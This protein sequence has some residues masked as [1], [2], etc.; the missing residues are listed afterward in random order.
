MSAAVSASTIK[1]S[2][3]SSTWQSQ[4]CEIILCL[5]AIIA[6]IALLYGCFYA[7][8]RLLE[9]MIKLFTPQSRR[10]RDYP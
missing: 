7:Y 5:A 2:V 8:F 1:H 4:G 10:E 3:S 9:K 6:A